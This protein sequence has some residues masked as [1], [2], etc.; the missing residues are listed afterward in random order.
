MIE[1][2]FDIPSVCEEPQI[3]SN[4]AEGFSAL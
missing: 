1:K 4:N 2:P 3:L